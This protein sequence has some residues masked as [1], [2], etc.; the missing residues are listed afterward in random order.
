MALRDWVRLPT[1]WIMSDGLT[2]F[3]WNAA[4]GSDNVAALMALIAIAHHA[5]DETVSAN[6][7]YDKLA[8]AT[9]LSRAKL[10]AGLK[11]L[12][13]RGIITRKADG[14][15]SFTLAGYDPTRNWAKV[16]ARRLYTAGGRISFFKELSL[17]KAVELH[18][19]KI[20]LLFLAMR[21]RK[22]NMALISYDRIGDY[23]SVDR[24]RITSAISL[25]AANS[26]IRIERGIASGEFG[27]KSSYRIAHLETSSHMGTTGRRMLSETGENSVYYED[28]GMVIEAG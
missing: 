9:T 10:S 15:S 4:E 18:A 5:D 11:V 26:L 13:A 16:P 8:E 2:E 24:S 3:R 6:V 28:M 7:T 1:G 12:E 25:L 20:Y 17:R 27:V 14:R 21:D 19:L 22:T 23:T